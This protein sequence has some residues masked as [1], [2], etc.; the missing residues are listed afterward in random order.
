MKSRQVQISNL[1]DMED[2]Q[3]V[4]KEVRHI[5][6][7][8][9]PDF[10]MAPLDHVFVDVLKLFK[11]E[12]P[13][14]QACDTTYHDLKHTTDTFL[15]MARIIHGAQGIENITKWGVALGLISA[16]FHDSGYILALDE[17][18]PGARF[19]QV[20]IRRSIAFMDTYFLEKGFSR[21]DFHFCRSIL[22]CTGLD[23]ELDRLQFASSENEILG[24]MLGSA[25]LLGQMADRTYL[26][27]LPFLYDEFKI[28]NIT[29]IDSELSFFKNTPA[30]FQ[31]TKDRFANE[32]GG[33]NCHMRR[34]FRKRWGIDQD[35]Y[36][37][38]IENSMEHLKALI[39]RHPD[40]YRKNLRRAGVIRN[41]NRIRT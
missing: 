3:A 10:D 21:K 9:F 24:K 31:M 11:G 26:E 22:E 7:L 23:V 2:P 12:Y 32:L 15:A 39:E 14:Y 38:A 30:F 20:H 5:V 18:G 40:D 34:H 27:K 29:G 1:V 13:A 4:L 8:M 16:L 33:V 35:L 36:M 28:A 25:D 37:I 41:L 19:T 17:D 6:F